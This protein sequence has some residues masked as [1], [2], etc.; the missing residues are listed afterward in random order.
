MVD[1]DKYI[2]VQRSD[3]GIDYTIYDAGSAKVL[4]G[5][6]DVYKRQALDTIEHD[7]YVLISMITALHQGEW[8][9]DEVQ[10][11]LQMQRRNHGNEHIGDVYKR[12]V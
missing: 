1:N 2:H 5:G 7:P 4:D 6:V 12:Q 11:T 9:L 3:T 8:T 10:G